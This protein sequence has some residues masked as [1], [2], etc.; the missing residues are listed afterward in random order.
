MTGDRHLLVIRFSAMGD[1]AM[2]VPVVKALL[3][4]NPYVRIT[5][6]SRPG[7]AGFFEG[8]PRLTYHNADLDGRYKGFTGLLK[9]FT[10]LKKQGSYN[11]LA[12]LHDN[13]RT[14]IL[15]RLFGIAGLPTAS[16]DKGRK[17]K[18]LLTQFPGKVLQ[19]LKLTTE[20]YADVFRKLGYRIVLDHKLI[21][22]PAPL[23]SEIT[24]ITGEKKRKWVGIAPFAR[25]KGKIYPIER[26][27]EV[28]K[29][30]NANNVTI[31]LFGGSLLEE[32]IC[33]QWQVDFENVISVV[34]KLAMQQELA[35][36]SQ[37]EVMLSMD[38]AGMHLA[39][40]V[41][42]PVVS[43]WGATHH[44]AG[45][46]G[47]G[48]S[49]DNIVADDIECRPCSV[50]GNKPCFRGD[51]ACLYRIEYEAIIARLAKFI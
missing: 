31:F 10:D 39:S 24:G 20:R 49:E 18:K 19:P 13:L 8:I 6:V 29:W 17:E 48:Q 30:L 5:Y 12:D 7:F 37:L 3:D 33:R 38:S 34:N 4:Q 1:V 9:L 42:V 22:N 23:T 28:V 43:V 46:L 45:F 40:L 14:K 26:M 2:T 41:G 16:I 27:R 15:R 47:Y 25:H 32:E 35:L 50:Y 11:A 51:Y 21:K 44:Y 36:V